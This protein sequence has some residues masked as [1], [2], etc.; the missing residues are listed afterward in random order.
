MLNRIIL[1][2]VLGCFALPAN[3]AVQNDNS[4]ASLAAQNSALCGPLVF[5]EEDSAKKKDGKKPK[6]SGDGSN[7][8]DNCDD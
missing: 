8:E 7:P 6:P 2:A 5:E 4:R 1:S 3:A